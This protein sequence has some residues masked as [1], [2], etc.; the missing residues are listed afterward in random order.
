MILDTSG[1][2]KKSLDTS[3]PLLISSLFTAYWK[4]NWYHLEYFFQYYFLNIIVN[5]NSLTSLNNFAMNITLNIF[6]FELKLMERAI[7]F[8]SKIWL[9]YGN[10]SSM[11][12]W[13][14]KFLWKN[15]KNSHPSSYILNVCSLTFKKIKN[16]QKTKTNKQII[17]KKII[18][19]IAFHFWQFF[20]CNSQ[21][22][23][24]KTNIFLHLNIIC[25]IFI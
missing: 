9:S 19:T 6:V 18:W 1:I 20:F 22:Q 3:L 24:Q 25:A 16:K 8:F 12:L 13:A 17:K 23:K 10:L 11:V 7:I 4:L 15:L 2:P 5:I 21:F 14:T